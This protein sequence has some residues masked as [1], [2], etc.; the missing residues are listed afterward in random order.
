MMCMTKSKLYL[1]L[2][3]ILCILL[4]MILVAMTIGIYREGLERRVEHPLDWIYTREIVAEKF[5][6]IAPLFF[7]AIGLGIA[8]MVLDVKDEKAGKPVQDIELNRNLIIT[9]VVEPSEAMKKEHE[10][11]KK[12]FWGGWAAFAVCCIPI[13]LY[14]CNGVH[15]PNDDLEPMIA[16]LAIHV[17]P[18]MALA[19]ACLMM[20][21]ILQEKSMIRECAAAQERIRE[22]KAAGIKAEGKKDSAPRNREVLQTVLIVAAIVLIIAGIFN[23]S[24]R[25]VLYKAAKICTECVGLG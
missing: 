10:R 16:E 20:S 15:F 13:L 3:S 2:Q 12:L 22:E 14:M 21:T 11:Q 6:H 4:V 17:L 24:A 7:A 5:S 23:G 8:G 25:D 9:R 18:W 19:V 1:I